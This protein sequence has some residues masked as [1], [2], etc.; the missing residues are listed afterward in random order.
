MVKNAIQ[1]ITNGVSDDCDC[2][3]GIAQKPAGWRLTKPTGEHRCDVMAAKPIQYKR[4]SLPVPVRNYDWTCLAYL[5]PS[6]LLCCY[7]GKGCPNT[8][9]VITL[10]NTEDTVHGEHV[11]YPPCTIEEIDL[12]YPMPRG[13]WENPS[14]FQLVGTDLYHLV[15]KGLFVLD[16]AA[17]PRQ[18]RSL[19]KLPEALAAVFHANPKVVDN[20]TAPRAHKLL[21]LCGDLY[22]LAYHSEYMPDGSTYP[23]SGRPQLRPTFQFWRYEIES[24]YWSCI[25]TDT[26]PMTWGALPDCSHYLSGEWVLVESFVSGDTLWLGQCQSMMTYRPSAAG[27]GGVWQLHKDSDEPIHTLPKEGVVVG[28]YVI[29]TTIRNTSYDTLKAEIFPETETRGWVEDSVYA[30]GY[31]DVFGPRE[32]CVYTSCM[33]EHGKGVQI[34]DAKKLKEVVLAVPQVDRE[35]L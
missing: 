15:A 23:D 19:G 3:V 26:M 11:E 31:R 21:A 27:D 32:G 22:V 5:S 35:W 20:P 29:G 30:K 10:P 34:R 18:W 8:C 2:R 24:A 33:T 9:C 13:R 4:F 14:H 6:E 25:P 1:C 17:T 12:P 28:Q 7:H 16:C